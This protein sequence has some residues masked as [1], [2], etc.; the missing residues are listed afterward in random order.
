MDRRISLVLW[1]WPLLVIG[2]GCSGGSANMA[3]VTGSVT[4]RG[5]PLPD[6]Q[7]SFAPADGGP[8]ATGRTDSS[9]KFRLGT[10][11]ADDGARVGKHRISIVARGPDRPPRAGETGSGMPGE[12][13]PGDP[14]I[15]AKYFSAETSGLERE[16]VRGSNDFSIALE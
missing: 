11:A 14:L 12:S 13:M 9:G 15:P 6:A 3:Q 2:I 8:I 4:Y 5:Q 10:L 16:V 1:T 7:V